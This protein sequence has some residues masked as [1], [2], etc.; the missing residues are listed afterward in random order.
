MHEMSLA[1]SILETVAV[2]ALGRPVA[3]V[4]AHVGEQLAAFA[5]PLQFG[6]ELASAGGVCEGAVLEV[7]PAQGDG[8]VIELIEYRS[9]DACV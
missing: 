7:V 2:R 6:F 8:I 4:R 5:E 1:E 9:E 3:R